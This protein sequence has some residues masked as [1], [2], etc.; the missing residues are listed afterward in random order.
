MHVSRPRGSGGQTIP[1]Q[2]LPYGG[3]GYNK[4]QPHPLGGREGDVSNITHAKKI[5]SK[6][7][8]HVKNHEEQEKRP[9]GPGPSSERY[10]DGYDDEGEVEQLVPAEIVKAEKG[11]RWRRGKFRH[12]ASVGV[13]ADDIGARCGSR[14]AYRKWKARDGTRMVM[15]QAA[16]DAAD[17]K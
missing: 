11:E 8:G 17:G 1:V 2:S 6:T 7:N 9:R 15:G 5:E 13:D 4:Q 14:E 16:R 10:R 3:K 12:P